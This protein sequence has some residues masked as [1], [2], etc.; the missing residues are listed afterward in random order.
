M[1][2]FKYFLD[3]CVN[4]NVKY[5]YFLNSNIQFIRPICNLSLQKDYTF[6]SHSGYFSLSYKHCT[7]EKNNNSVAYVDKHNH[8]NYIGGGIYGGKRAKFIKM[9]HKLST[10]I[11]KDE[12]KKYIAVWH[13]ESHLNHYY[14]VILKGNSDKI[15]LLPPSFHIPSEKIDFYNKLYDKIMA[16]YI[17]KEPGF[18]SK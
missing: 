7:Y 18:I 1:Y 3:F 13:D 15:E 9:S 16:I 4:D 6:V 11:E 5:L 8:I 2:R 17:L 14:N 10:N 12:S